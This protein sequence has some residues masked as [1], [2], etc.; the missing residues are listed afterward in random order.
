VNTKFALKLAT[1]LAAKPLE[2]LQAKLIKVAK[3][4]AVATLGIET[5]ME[6]ILLMSSCL[7]WTYYRYLQGGL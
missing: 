2:K 1:K 3:A 6:P 4:S 5:Q 7:R